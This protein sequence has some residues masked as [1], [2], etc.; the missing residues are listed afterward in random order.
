MKTLTPILVALTLGLN[1]PLMFGG[2]SA[3]F[4]FQPMAVRQGDWWRLITH[5]FVHVSLYHF[6]LD[7]G[8]FFILWQSRPS[9]RLMHHD[10]AVLGWCAGGSLLGALWSGIP[11]GGFGGLSGIAHGL[12]AYQGMRW[13]TQRDEP[14]TNRRLGGLLVLVVIGKAVLETITGQVFFGALHAGS[15]GTPITAC[16]LGGALAGSLRG[17]LP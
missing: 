8:A 16:H 11:P 5:P 9:P 17:R 12:M 2:P 1:V 14:V 6:I 3:D 7:A 15:V 10:L 4:L 13:M